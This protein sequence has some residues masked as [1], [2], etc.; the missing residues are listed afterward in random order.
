VLQL[1]VEIHTADMPRGGTDDPVY[2]SV[3]LRSGVE[4]VADL[5]L[6]REGD[7]GFAPGARRRYLLPLPAGLAAT[8]TSDEIERITLRKDGDDGWALGGVTLFADGVE[9]FRNLSINQFLDGGTAVL[10]EHTWVSDRVVGPV[11]GGLGPDFAR[12]QARIEQ[13]GTVEARLTPPSG[14]SL[15]ASASAAPTAVIEID[16]LTP[17]TTYAYRLFRA[18]VPIPDTDGRLRTFPPENQGSAFSFAFGSCV[19][20]KYDSVQHAWDQLLGLADDLRFFLHLGDTFYFLDADVL[21]RFGATKDIDRALRAAHLSSRLHPKFLRMARRLPCVAVWDDHDFAGNN[22][23]GG[24]FADRVLARDAFVSYWANPDLGS[25]WR[26]FGLTSRLSIGRADLYLMDG[27]FNRQPFGD[28]FG[29]GQCELV[30]DAIDSRAAALGPRLVFLASGSPWHSMD[31]TDSYAE[32]VLGAPLYGAERTRFFAGLAQRIE[33]GRIRGLVLLAGDA[34]RAEIYETEFAD[35]IAA[36]ELVSSGLAMPRRPTD[37][38]PTTRERRFSRGVDPDDG[39]FAQF[40]VVSV[41]TSAPVP[42]GNWS[43]RAD[44]RRSD[45]GEIFFT[46]RYVLTDNQFVWTV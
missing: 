24:S 7:N 34:H 30:L 33:D 27:R 43:L 22:S 39:S 26:A 17:D 37:S 25:A 15:V 4:I 44:F 6:G 9:V 1:E 21:G 20:N 19:R 18:G 10:G 40:C 16:G 23:I 29:A 5:R 38:R 32:R 41:D 11:L 3:R 35:R 42:N 46:K 13:G 14:P 2:C 45:N 31:Q 28:F 8:V 36:P 12:I